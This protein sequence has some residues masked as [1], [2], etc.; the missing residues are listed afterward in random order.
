MTKKLLVLAVIA[1]FVVNPMTGAESP[2]TLP[3]SVFCFAQQQLSVLIKHVDQE[4]VKQERIKTKESDKTTIASVKAW[5]KNHLPS[6]WSTKSDEKRKVLIVPTAFDKKS[7]KIVWGDIH[8]WRSG[9]YPG[10][11]WLMYEATNKAY[12]KQKAQQYTN[13]LYP[14]CDYSKHDLGFMV[15]NSFGKAYELSGGSKK[16]KE[17]I[18]IAANTLCTRYNKNVG[19]IK[20]WNSTSKWEYPVIIDNMMNLEL[21]FHAYLITG[22]IKYRQVAMR[23]ADK[24]IKNHFRQDYSSYHVVDYDSK[25]GKPRKKG[26]SQGYSDESY[27]SRGQ[28]WGL[29]GFTMCYR[30]TKESRY[31]FQAEHIADFL[32]KLQYAE[33]LIPY[34]DMKCPDIPHT[35]R[36]A[37]SAAIMAS[38][39]LELSSYVKGYKGK[40]YEAYSKRLLK[41]LHNAYQSNK[42]DN[43]GFLLDH[44]TSFFTGN[45]DVDAPIIYADYYY[46][47]ALLRL[48]AI[49]HGKSS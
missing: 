1:L 12:Y 6:F 19:A 3:D 7:G 39:L 28:A 48:R 38:A 29:Y 26:T 43:G 8:D 34:W 13:K 18:V 49:N 10:M 30:F 27:W 15:N 32:L 37:S 22:N 9:F 40:Q 42:G 11:L 31:L 16:Y 25:S 35:A 45:Q 24:T 36:D 5:I 20:S 44:S 2:T 46:L 17:A 23:H 21:L 47:E 41:S 33:D 14:V 4:V